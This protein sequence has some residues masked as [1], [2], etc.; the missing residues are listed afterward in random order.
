MNQEHIKNINAILSYQN[1]LKNKAKK[2]DS[3]IIG[4]L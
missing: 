1:E 2:K 4:A 3:D